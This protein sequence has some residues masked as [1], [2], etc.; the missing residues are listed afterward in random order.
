M[1]Y[2]PAAIPL[3]AIQDLHCPK[4]R[5]RMT[6]WHMRPGPSGFELRTFDC[7]KCDHVEQIAIAS[8]D[9]HAIRCGWLVYWRTTAAEVRAFRLAYAACAVCAVCE[10]TLSGGGIDPPHHGARQAR[11]GLYGRRR[12]SGVGFPQR[13]F[14]LALRLRVR[15]AGQGA[16]SCDNEIYDVP[17]EAADQHRAHGGFV[18]EVPGEPEDHAQCQQRPAE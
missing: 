13:S 9:S 11:C 10:A 14:W 8:D 4:C 6:L 12:R 2:Y 15:R 5:T 18:T 7:S 3:L 16:H 17:Y 1:T